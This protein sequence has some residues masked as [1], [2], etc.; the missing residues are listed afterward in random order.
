MTEI[1]LLPLTQFPTQLL[2][3]FPSS[4]IINFPLLLLTSYPLYH[5]WYCDSK[6]WSQVGA[7][8]WW[9]IQ[10][11]RDTGPALWISMGRWARLSLCFPFSPCSYFQLFF[12]VS[13]QS[14]PQKKSMC[15]T[16]KSTPN[17]TRLGKPAPSLPNLPTVPASSCLRLRLVHWGQGRAR[18][19]EQALEL[20][21]YGSVRRLGWVIF[22]YLQ[23]QYVAG[24]GSLPGLIVFTFIILIKA[25]E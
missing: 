14:T 19:T 21:R 8:V 2:S 7:G 10:C 15:I 6:P 18:I 24:L 1:F 13:G 22:L 20:P 5:S 11:I 17:N 9:I 16:L 3:L 25:S 4:L 23:A 12:P